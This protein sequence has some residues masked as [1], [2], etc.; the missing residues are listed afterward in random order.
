MNEHLRGIGA[1][2]R[3]AIMAT[4]DNPFDMEKI[5]GAK[6]CVTHHYSPGKL[7]TFC[8]GTLISFL[9]YRFMRK[10]LQTVMRMA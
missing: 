2:P 7:F 1:E 4:N 3:I 8:G 9:L 6:N 10:N 5:L